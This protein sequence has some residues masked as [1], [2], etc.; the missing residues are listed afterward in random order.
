[1]LLLVFLSF[2]FAP[3]TT[4]MLIENAEFDKHCF[5]IFYSLI[6]SETFLQPSLSV[7]PL[8]FRSGGMS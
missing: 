8:V 5:C 1:M 6:E 4:Y 7:F 2:S 3:A